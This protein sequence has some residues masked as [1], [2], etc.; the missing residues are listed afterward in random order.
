MPSIPSGVIIIWPGDDDDIPS[1]W[2]S[3][4]SLD[5]IFAKGTANG[6]NPDV[7]GGATTHIHA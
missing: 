4:T 2:D 1:G 7:T 3:E 6:V 5:T